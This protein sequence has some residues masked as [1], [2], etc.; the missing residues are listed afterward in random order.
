[1]T[2][3]TFKEERVYYECDGCGY[4]LMDATKAN[5]DTDRNFLA[6]ITL[7][8]EGNVFHFHNS[9]KHGYSCFKYWLE[10]KVEGEDL[11]A[12]IGKER[13]AT[14]WPTNVTA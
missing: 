2:R 3:H 10:H 9:V 12:L 13:D 14:Y 7:N 5:N 4:A 8:I 6:P 1:M 11:D